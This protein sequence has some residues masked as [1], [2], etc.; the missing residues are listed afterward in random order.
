[1]NIDLYKSLSEIVILLLL[2]VLSISL[3]GGQI[4]NA[5]VGPGL[6]IGVL[7]VGLLFGHFGFR[8]EPTTGSIGFLLFIFYVC[9]QAGPELL[10]HLH[11]HQCTAYI[12]WQHHDHVMSQEV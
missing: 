10:R 2:F 6:T 9:L 5:Q 11:H 12:C 4:R 8:I 1:M 7:I 3:S